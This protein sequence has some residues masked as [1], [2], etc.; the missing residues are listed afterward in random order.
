MIHN[1]I[2][3]AI[4][5]AY[6]CINRHLTKLKCM[7]Y[8]SG[9]MSNL[10]QNKRSLSQLLYTY[11]YNHNTQREKTECGNKQ[12]KKTTKQ[13]TS[14]YNKLAMTSDRPLVP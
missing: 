4:Q 9:R 12:R 5:L 10:H 2:Y 11:M 7:K 14:H 6:C 8:F 3:F 13:S 1:F